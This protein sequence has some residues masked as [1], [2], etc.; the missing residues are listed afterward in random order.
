MTIGGVFWIEEIIN[1]IQEAAAGDEEDRFGD[2]DEATNKKGQQASKA[3]K[4]EN[5]YEP[6][7]R[8]GGIGTG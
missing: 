6:D 8:H 1:E 3:W 7:E 4:I 5:D 2:E